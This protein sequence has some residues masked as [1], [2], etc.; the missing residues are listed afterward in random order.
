MPR[1][2]RTI[3]RTKL[4]SQERERDY[5]DLT[6][7]ER[8]AMVDTLTRTAWAFHTGESSEPRLSRDVGR[9]IRGRR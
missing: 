8:L 4:A 2:K 3:R 5:R 7:G 1:S 9:V 6:A